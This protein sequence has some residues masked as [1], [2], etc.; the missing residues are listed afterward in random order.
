MDLMSLFSELTFL[1]WCGIATAIV[2][3]LGMT[4]WLG[5]LSEK[6]GGDRESGALVGFFVPGMV[7]LVVW[8]AMFQ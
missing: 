2:V 8:W 7:A 3:W 6:R 5:E 4:W 1:Q